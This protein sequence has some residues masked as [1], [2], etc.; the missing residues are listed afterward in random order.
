MDVSVD[1][2]Y[3]GDGVRCVFRMEG[4]SKRTTRIF[5][6]MQSALNIAVFIAGQAGILEKDRLRVWLELRGFEV[7][8]VEVDEDRCATA[9]RL[10]GHGPFTLRQGGEPEPRIE[11]EGGGA[12]RKIT[13][14]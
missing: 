11:E 10:A 7:E 8:S 12:P 3:K 13:D 6:S 14:S 2:D 9:A 4:K 5:D 1:R